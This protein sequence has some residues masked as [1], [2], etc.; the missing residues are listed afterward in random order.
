LVIKK[1]ILYAGAYTLL[2]ANWQQISL[3]SDC[4]GKEKIRSGKDYL[5]SADFM[6][7]V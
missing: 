3:Q 7:R 6:P 4:L 2:R 5:S 1:D